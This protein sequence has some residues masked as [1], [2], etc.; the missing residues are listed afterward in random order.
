M[1]SVC[2]GQVIAVDVSPRRDRRSVSAETQP[3]A[4]WESSRV[5]RSRVQ[6]AAS[7]PNSFSIVMR[8]MM[9]NSVISAESMKRYIDLYLKPPIEQV[10]MFDW[11]AGSMKSRR[12]DTATLSIN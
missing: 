12:S 11:M 10:E 8:T 9:L 4:G 3:G 2:E 1:S 6:S 7:A 5:V